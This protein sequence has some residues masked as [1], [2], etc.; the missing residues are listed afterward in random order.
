VKSASPERGPDSNGWYNHPVKINFSGDD[1]TSGVSGCTSPTYS[2]PDSGNAT[3]EGSCSD[4]AGNASGSLKYTFAYDATPPQVGGAK[5]SRQPDVNGWFNHPVDVTFE[6][7]D[8]ASGIDGCTTLTYKGPDTAAGVKGTCKDKA[9]ITAPEVVAPLKYDSTPPKLTA[10]LAVVSGDR[11][12][13]RWYASKD[14]QTFVVERFPGKGKARKSVVFRGKLRTF[15]DH[16]LRAGVR[17]RYRVT[18]VDEAGNAVVKAA[19]AR[20]GSLPAKAKGAAKPGARPKAKPKSKPAASGPLMSPPDGAYVEAPVLLRWRAVPKATYY[21]VQIRDA[22]GNKILSIW[23]ASSRL[24]VPRHWVFDG[25]S[26]T[27][28][29][30]QYRW[31]VWP[32]FGLR[33]SAK[34][35]AHLVTGHFVVTR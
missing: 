12:V 14:A 16:A 21:N 29:P 11:A 23:P 24:L 8:A 10:V 3:V 17:Y 27:L 5:T 34:Y 4:Y 33:S 35:G 1:A 32:G 25:V 9:G 2:G 28:A 7:S 31:D 18:A 15:T 13:V 20:S 19:V 22:K 6:G 26:H 30:G